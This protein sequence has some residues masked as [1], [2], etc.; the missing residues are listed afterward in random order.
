MNLTQPNV[1]TIGVSK[2]Y[3]SLLDIQN[4]AQL[5]QARQ[6]DMQVQRMQID[7]ARQQEMQQ[8]QAQQQAAYEKAAIGKLLNEHHDRTTGDV[9]WDTVSKRVYDIPG[10]SQ[11][12]AG[13]FGSMASAMSYAGQLSDDDPQKP[14]MRS[15]ASKGDFDNMQK[16][17]DSRE[18]RNLTGAKYSADLTLDTRKQTEEERHNK[19]MEARSRE[20]NAIAL[21]EKETQ[22]HDK[23][24]AEFSKAIDP[25]GQVRGPLGVSKQVFDRAERLESLAS[26]LPDGNL[27]S[28]QV[29]ELAIGLN[30]MLSGSNTGAQRQVEALVPRSVWGNVKK[31]TEFLVNNPQGTQQQAFVKRMLGSI[32]REK[33][34][35][36]DQINRTQFARIAGYSDLEKA[37]PVRFGEVLQSQGVD[38]ETYKQWKSSGF[39]SISAVQK[40]EGLSGPKVGTVE[41]G[42]KFKGGDPADKNNWEK[43]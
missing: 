8:Q 7:A 27:D 34:T 17:I 14:I 13:S 32:A 24:F 41:G 43:Q 6:Q 9:D 36:A 31:L 28:R 10:I 23:R 22:F 30:A 37:D 40:P 3:S 26:A 42:Y 18:T 5:M 2:P 11:Q 39:K 38:P 1:G 19:A 12:A 21:G 25:S 4:N 33:Q 29:E 35:A 16:L 20:G 15:L